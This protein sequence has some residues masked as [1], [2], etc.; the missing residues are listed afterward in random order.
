V[1]PFVEQ[2]RRRNRC[3]A[4]I[5]ASTSKLSSTPRALHGLAMDGGQ[6]DMRSDFAIVFQSASLGRDR[7]L[8]FTQIAVPSSRSK[9]LRSEHMGTAAGPSPS[10][11][12]SRR[13]RQRRRRGT[14]C[15]TVDV[16][17]SEIAALLPG[18]ICPR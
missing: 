7:P 4:V 16:N 3:L 5:P 12:R 17:E 2:I 18:A 15:I 1:L 10:T 6:E 11:E 14:R 8:A 9:M 13:H